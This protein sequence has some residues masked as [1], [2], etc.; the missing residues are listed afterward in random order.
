MDS[1]NIFVLEDELI[2]GENI[3]IFL[4][5]IGYNCH[6]PVTSKYEAIETLKNQSFDIALLDINLFGKNEGIEVAEFINQHVK[7]PFIFLTSNADKKTVDEAKKTNPNA[8]LLKP[9]NKDDLFTAIEIALHN[10][11]GGDEVADPNVSEAS[12]LKDSFF[13]KVGNRYVKQNIHEITYFESD[14]KYIIL[15]NTELKSFTIRSGIDELL[16]KCKDFGFMR[17]HRSYCINI[18]FV[19]E[20]S[21]DH[22][23]ISG[24]HIPIGR[25]YREEVM[26]VINKLY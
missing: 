10:N 22:M 15:Y 16:L 20:I 9:F 23:I 1:V 5:E 21:Y 19:K 17:V 13:I 2:V 12:I 4:S 11:S 3:R 26:K 8:Y 6:E 24:K 7:I 14:G 25:L 18:N